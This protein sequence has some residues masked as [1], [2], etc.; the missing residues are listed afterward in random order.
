M[1]R[2]ILVI[3]RLSRS[4]ATPACR[5]RV[6]LPACIPACGHHLAAGADLAADGAS[7]R[8]L[9]VLTWKDHPAAGGTPVVA[10]ELAEPELIARHAL[11]EARVEAR[12][13]AQIHHRGSGRWRGQHRD[14]DD[15]AYGAEERGHMP[16]CRSPRLLCRFAAAPRAPIALLALETSPHL[17]HGQTAARCLIYIAGRG[18][19]DPGRDTPHSS[20]A[21]EGGG[22]RDTGWEKE[23]EVQETNEERKTEHRCDA[24]FAGGVWPCAEDR[25][26]A[27]GS[28]M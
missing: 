22:R 25:A 4:C 9:A 1:M 11:V 14:H 23:E 24:G 16:L 26:A 18:G 21:R 20:A 3:D 28:C 17:G 12:P 2:S 13:P 10:G 27:H 6:A 15:D 19:G 7:T 5:H 8:V